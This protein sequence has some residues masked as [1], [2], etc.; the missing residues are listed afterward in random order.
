MP[1]LVSK[2]N[3]GKVL[4][5]SSLD[6]GHPGDNI[7]DG[8]DS[9]YWISTGLYPQE[10]LLQLSNP[11]P[12]NNVKIS[13]TNVKTVRIESCAEENPVNFKTLAEGDLEESSGRL[14]LK[15]LPCYGSS[16]PAAYVKVMILSGWSDFCSVHKVQVE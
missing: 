4:M 12:V 3:G 7:I 10:I 13:T 11:A 1:D 14:Q 8:N 15:E 5:I 2:K 6:Q 9:S 16:E